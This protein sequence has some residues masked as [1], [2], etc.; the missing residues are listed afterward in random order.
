MD[1]DM[2]QGMVEVKVLECLKVVMEKVVVA[3][4]DVV[5]EMEDMVAVAVLAMVPD[6]VKVTELVSEVMR[7][8]VVVAVVEDKV[9]GMDLDVDLVGVVAM[10][11]VKEEVLVTTKVLVQANPQFMT[12][13][14]VVLLKSHQNSYAGVWAQ[15]NVFTYSKVQ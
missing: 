7:K 3:V 6:M 8:V 12:D 5:V 2:V 13:T 14:K 9:V 15:H 10:D 4:A 11:R 1:Q